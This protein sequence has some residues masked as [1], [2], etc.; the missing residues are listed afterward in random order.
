MKVWVIMWHI[1]Y[2]DGGIDGVYSTLEKAEKRKT[3]LEKDRS[4]SNCHSYPDW[5]IIEEVEVE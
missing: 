1:D 3:I 4:L 5:F 2:E